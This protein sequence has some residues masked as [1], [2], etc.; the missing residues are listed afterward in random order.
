MIHTPGR[1]A[2]PRRREGESMQA[3]RAVRV[4]ELE[5]RVAGAGCGSDISYNRY[6]TCYQ[7]LSRPGA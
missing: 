3:R 7:L 4:P 5:D 6:S 2:G 1:G